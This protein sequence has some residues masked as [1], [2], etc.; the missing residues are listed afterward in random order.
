MSRGPYTNGVRLLAGQF[1]GGLQG[2][3]KVGGI[4]RKPPAAL[5]VQSG[6]HACTMAIV[7]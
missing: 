2:H 1:S 7:W 6:D 3:W 5:L 4:E